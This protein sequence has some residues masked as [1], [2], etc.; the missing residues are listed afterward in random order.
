MGMKSIDE[1]LKEK[2]ATAERDSIVQFSLLYGT[3]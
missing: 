2:S 1:A 3:G